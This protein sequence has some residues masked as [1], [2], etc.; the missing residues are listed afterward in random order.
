[1]C[2]HLHTPPPLA[3]ARICTELRGE[4]GQNDVCAHPKPMCVNHRRKVNI[5]MWVCVRAG[6][7]LALHLCRRASV[8]KVALTLMHAQMIL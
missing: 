8:Q 7:R 2:T 1:M 3:G 4:W 5:Y 6:A